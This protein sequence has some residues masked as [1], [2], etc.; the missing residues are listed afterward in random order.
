MGNALANYDRTVGSGANSYTH[1]FENSNM[2]DTGKSVNIQFPLP[3]GTCTAFPIKFKLVME[4]N[5]AAGVIDSDTC[6]LTTSALP[7]KVGGTLIADS[8]GGVEPIKRSITDTPTIT[9]DDPYQN[10]VTILPEGYTPGVTTWADI[11]GKIF[12][13]DMGEISVQTIYEGDI[14]MLKFECT[15]IDNNAEIVIYSLIVEGVSHQDGKG[16]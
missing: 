2:D 6:V 11:S 12:E 1:Y 5:G 4:V 3:I 10:V 14:V 8:S 16:I 9:T 15:T 7:E 13:L